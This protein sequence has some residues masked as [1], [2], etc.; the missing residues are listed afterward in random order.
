MGGF[1]QLDR[2][3]HGGLN[4]AFSCENIVG[5]LRVNPRAPL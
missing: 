3:R 4:I 1:G 5:R 2:K